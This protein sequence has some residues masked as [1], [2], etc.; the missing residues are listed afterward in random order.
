VPGAPREGRC[1]RSRSEYLVQALADGAVLLGHDLLTKRFDYGYF[2][3]A[4]Q[5]IWDWFVVAEAA[6]A[7][8]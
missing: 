3:E 2:P 7:R 6:P 8:R 1:R 4:N 5:E